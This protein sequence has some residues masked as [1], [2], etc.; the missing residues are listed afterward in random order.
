MLARLPQPLKRVIQIVIDYCLLALAA[1]LALQLRLG[2][3]YNVNIS[4]TVMI[5]IA[6]LCAIP[7]FVRFGLYRQ[8]L[9]YLPERVLLNILEATAL[10]SVLWLAIVF[11]S[12][13]YG[14]AGV[15]RSVP[16]LYFLLALTI[17]A[18][19]RYLAKW[20]LFGRHENTKKGI[21]T[22]IYGAGEAG[23]QLV[24]ALISSPDA[25]VVGF[26]DDDK[27]LHGRYV[28]GHRV[29]SP[30]ALPDLV[31]NLGVES[32]ILCVP[33]VAGSRKLEIVSNLAK[34]P[35]KTQIVPSISDI[36]S[37][38]YIVDNVQKIELADLIGRSRVPPDI[39]LIDS[40]VRGK[41]VLVTGAGGSIG[42]ALVNLIWLHAPRSIVL[43]DNN[44]FA[45][46]EVSRKLNALDDSI[47]FEA[48]LASAADE[49]AMEAVFDQHQPE[50]VFHAAAYKH[51]D[52]VER[53]PAEAIR[54]NVGSTEVLARL[55]YSRQVER[56][57][58]ISSD[59]AVKP[60]NVMGAT[61]RASELITRK[62]A[63]D[64]LSGETGQVF[65]AVRFGNVVGSRG[66]VVPLFEE[67][68]RNGGPVTVTDRRMT[69]YFMSISEAVELIVQAAGL[70][71]GGETFLLEMGEPISIYRLARNMIGMS[72]L[73]VRDEDNPG[74]DIEIIFTG[75][76][77]GEKIREEL[78]YDP[79]NNIRTRHPKIVKAKRFTSAQEYIMSRLDELMQTT[80]GPDRM[81]SGDKLFDILRDAERLRPIK[82]GDV[83]ADDENNDDDLPN[84][85]RLRPRK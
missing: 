60:T 7:I 40:V 50:I 9:R 18:A 70:A 34:L 76:K 65:L 57:V 17:V 59:K 71:D 58:L 67:Q 41:R 30:T 53:N 66:S 32:I 74:G 1:W 5:A 29:Y 75:A 13:Q 79:A 21:R 2:F 54:N 35:V 15:P 22:M 37:G 27:Q 8:V 56:F 62:Y 31:R 68:I 73:A 83:A 11:F 45:L 24:Q 36:A 81:N 16:M 78:F 42:S 51:V 19:T 44:E 28:A 33:S 48:V 39:E 69:R 10:A 38:R 61:K 26:V 6:P 77:A 46:F 12:G 82:P 25:S 3:G 47:R 4:Q 84:V 85:T 55:S 72:G 52:L 43:V 23:T 80:V 63:E 64:A 14:G 20:A 49:N